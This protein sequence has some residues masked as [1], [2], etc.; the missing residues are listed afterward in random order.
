MPYL[1]DIPGRSVLSMKGKEE[2]W[3]GSVE[4]VNYPSK[5]KE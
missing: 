2:E 4:G 3:V 1:V 5:V